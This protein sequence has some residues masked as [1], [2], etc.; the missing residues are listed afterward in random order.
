M[1]LNYL[2][3]IMEMIAGFILGCLL[4]TVRNSSGKIIIDKSNPEKDFY[5]FEIDDLSELDDKD[6]VRFR[7]ERIEEWDS[8]KKQILLWDNY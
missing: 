3:F 1:L 2:I 5:K 7:I 4:T 8:R 6:W